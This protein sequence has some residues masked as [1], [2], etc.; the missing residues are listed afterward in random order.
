MPSFCISRLRSSVTLY[1]GRSG[2]AALTLSCSM[3]ASK[4]PTL[5]S[6]AGQLRALRIDLGRNLLL[7][8]LRQLLAL[9]H[10]GR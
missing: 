9:L 4:V 7:I 8:E 10:A 5:A 2:A 1:M 3:L 6:R